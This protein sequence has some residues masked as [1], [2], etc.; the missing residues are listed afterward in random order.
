[1]V[2]PLIAIIIGAVF[3]LI[4][5]PFVIKIIKIVAVIVALLFIYKLLKRFKF[6]NM[7]N[8]EILIIVISAGA[9]I[10]ALGSHFG[11]F[12]VSGL[13]MAIQTPLVQA[14][15]SPLNLFLGFIIGVMVLMYIYK[16]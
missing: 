11:F 8:P 9:G 7:S 5:I 3:F 4:F 12:A 10:L 16:K 15:L 14:S 6:K 1:M 13:P 2:F